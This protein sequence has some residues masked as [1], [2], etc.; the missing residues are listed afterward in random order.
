VRSHSESDRDIEA[1]AESVGMSCDCCVSARAAFRES[2][3]AAIARHGTRRLENYLQ[4]EAE[5]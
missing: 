4:T 2:L 1:V 3:I 5:R